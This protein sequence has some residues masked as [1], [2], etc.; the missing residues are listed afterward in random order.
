[1]RGAARARRVARAR[2]ALVAVAAIAVPAASADGAKRCTAREI[3][4]PYAVEE[5]IHPTLT[6]LLEVLR[7]PATPEDAG[8][9]D[10]RFAGD[11]HKVSPSTMRLI[12]NVGGTR[13]WVMGAT[14]GLDR[15][16]ARCRRRLPPAA[17][18]REARWYRR[19]KARPL[20]LAVLTDGP[21]GS[22]GGFFGTAG[23]AADLLAGRMLVVEGEPGDVVTDEPVQ[24]FA[25]GLVPD[26][27]ASVAVTF[28]RDGGGEEVHEAAVNVN[29]WVV[30]LGPGV[31]PRPR[32]I[33]WRAVD[34]RT[35]KSFDRS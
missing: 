19:Q 20:R 23:T 17:R 16:H 6:R 35:I 4:E 27:V 14:V 26:G 13:V 29:A 30:E 8:G 5:P 1:M 22:S 28:A 18:R 11:F 10:M 24:P 12:A 31:S 25:A 32:R 2:I 33:T 15:M 9:Y 21:G 3:P 34:G 7:R